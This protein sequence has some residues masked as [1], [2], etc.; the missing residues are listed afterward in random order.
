MECLRIIE[1]CC[2]PLLL[3]KI[4]R[5]RALWEE[6]GGR[7]R[8]CPTSQKELLQSGQSLGPL[9]SKLTWDDALG[10]HG[11]LCLGPDLSTSLTA[12]QIRQVSS[13]DVGKCTAYT[14]H[15][16]RGCFSTAFV[17]D[18]VS[19]HGYTW[20]IWGSGVIH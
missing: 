11:H 4:R 8:A 3:S 16:T 13:M 15:D 2:E 7:P 20:L 17:S 14:Q 19:W 18:G 1:Q 10:G 12:A 9:L 5:L 6:R